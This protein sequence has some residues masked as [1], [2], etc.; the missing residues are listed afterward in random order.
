M[1][2]G[3]TGERYIPH[4]IEPALGVNRSMLAFLVDAYDEEVVAERERTVLRLHPQL[5]P[6]KAAVLPLIGK[7]EAM[8]GKARALYEELRR[9]SA[10]STTTAARSAGATAARTRSGR[11]TGSRSTSRRS[12]TT[13]SRSATATRS[14]RSGSRSA[15][16]ARSSSSCSAADWRSP[17]AGLGLARAALEHALAGAKPNFP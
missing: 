13:R 15:A 11:R 2:R 9:H 10:S 12:R 17:K 16:S 14:R 4:V 1:G 3:G 8:V 6:V 5:A 7:S